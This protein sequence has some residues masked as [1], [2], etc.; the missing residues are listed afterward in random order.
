MV[1]P[2]SGKFRGSKFSHF[3]SRR[4]FHSFNLRVQRELLTTPLYNRRVNR[5]RKMSCGKGQ[6]VVWQFEIAL[7]CHR[8]K[9]NRA[10]LVHKTHGV[11]ISKSSHVQIFTVSYFAVLIFTFWSW[12]V[13]IAKIW[14]SRKFPA[15]Q[16]NFLGHMIHHQYINT[17]INLK[18]TIMLDMHTIINVYS[19]L[20]CV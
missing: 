3:P 5:G 11:K 10:K 8:Q 7:Q 19:K 1:I 6:N 4:N 18:H 16:Y 13:K 9:S 15:I 2:Y 12:V 20:Y 17:H 14:T